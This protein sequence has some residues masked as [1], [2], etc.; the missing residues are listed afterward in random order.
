[1][2]SVCVA[3]YNGEKYIKEQLNSILIQ[4]D[5]D[6]EVIIS[7]DGSTDQ[8]LDIVRELKDARIQIV[9]NKNKHGFTH[10]FENALRNAKGDYIFL[11]DQ[12]DIWA[13]DKVAVTLE[14]LK[15]CDFVISDCVTVNYEMKILSK[16]RFEDFKM[17]PGFFRHLLK[18]RFLGCCMTFNRKV[19][20][21]A[22]PF[23]DR[24]DLV[25]HDIWLAA[26]AFCYF[27][28]QLV[29]KPLIYYRRHGKNASEGG[30]TKG[31]SLG[32]KLYRRLY[33][34][35]KLAQIRNKITTAKQNA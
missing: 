21:A 35:I 27:N 11:S 7:D 28:V 31:Y 4:L 18:S 9:I 1:M 17:K 24:D 14:V 25:E 29:N 13:E 30:F 33:R 22:L 26:V 2:I 34:C 10:N 8:T 15:K 16:S 6:D 32:N 20:D 23:P 5:T 12:D 19:L 3:T